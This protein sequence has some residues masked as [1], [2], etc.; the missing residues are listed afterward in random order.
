MNHGLL[1]SALR[2]L[3]VFARSRNLWLTFAAV[4]ALF[5][6]TG[7]FG[8]MESL[9]FLPRLFFWLTIHLTTWTTAIVFVV[10]GDVLL[11]PYLATMFW[12]MMAGSMVAAVPIGGLTQAVRYVWFGHGPLPA[13]VFGDIVM[14]LP[15]CILFC[16]ITFMTMSAENPG[17]FMS[18]DLSP[19]EAETAPA[20]AIPQAPSLAE[21]ESRQPPIIARL[22]PENRGRLQHLEVEDHYTNVRTSRGRE[23]ILLR[24]SDALRETGQQ[25]GLQV[26]RSHWVADDFVKTLARKHGRLTLV[27]A[28]GSEIPVSRTYAAAVRARFH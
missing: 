19:G 15:L 24:F 5:A 11:K 18:V 23:L 25:P 13:D 3:Q 9:R 6:V 7:P 14:A 22:K 20:A 8:T 28:D 10:L 26:H 1:H 12:R 2:E 21:P 16:L 4:I 27:L 17:S